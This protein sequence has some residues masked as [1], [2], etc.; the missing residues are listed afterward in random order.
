MKVV[1]LKGRLPLAKNPDKSARP[2]N[3]LPKQP[4]NFPKMPKAVWEEL[5]PQLLNAGLLTNVDGIAFALL[6]RDIADMEKVDAKLNKIDDWIDT[7]PNDYKVQSVWLNIRNRLHDDILRLCKEFGMTPASRS[8]LKTNI[9]NSSQRSFFD[10]DDLTPQK[11][12]PY[13]DFGA[14]TSH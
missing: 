2:E 7:T 10:D 6:C 12:D 3:V 8:T 9:T 5:A 11:A 4:K 13:A 1:D 14:R